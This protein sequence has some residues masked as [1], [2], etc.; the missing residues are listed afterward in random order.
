MP[1]LTIRDD[2]GDRHVAFVPGLS[3]LQLLDAAQV[4]IRGGCNGRGG[5]GLCLVRISAGDAGELAPIECLHLD[6][7]QLAQG[8][9][10]ACQALPQTDLT[11]QVLAPPP[12]AAWRYLD[13]R[14]QPPLRRTPAVP[15][16]LGTELGQAPYG[17][18]VD[19]GTTHLCLSLYDR[20][21]GQ[22][23][24]GCHGFNPQAAYGT[25]IMTRLAAAVASPAQAQ[26][27]SQLVVEG[28]GA[29]LWGLAIRAGIPLQHIGAVTL[30]GNTAMLALLSGRQCDRLLVP[31]QWALPIDCRPEA[32]DEWVQTW[33]IHPGARI[34][35]IAP[36]AGLI[37][38]DL[39]AGVLATD[40][41]AAEGGQ[42][43][44]DFGTNSE[45]AFWDG[46]VLWCTSAAGGPAFEGS[47]MRCGFPAEPGAIE[48]VEFADDGLHV[49]VIGGAQPQGLCGSG[50]VDLM[51]GLV[52]SGQL[53]SRGRFTSGVPEEGFHLGVGGRDLV[54][55]GADVD[56][57]QRAKAAIGVGI[58]VLL[59]RAGWRNKDLRQVCVGGAFGR[60][61]AIGNAQALG[62]LP[63]IAPERIALCGNTALAGCTAALLSPA[64]RER[65][66]RLVG[67]SRV[68]NLSACP[69]FDERFLDHLYLR[70]MVV[71]GP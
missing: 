69:D 36:V 34:D 3:L 2:T 49:Q 42:L 15:P 33:D 41:T 50:V 13:P 22:W 6:E 10:L 68:I 27:M 64:A 12:Q 5:C 55:T 37:G 30:V 44:I 59:D 58:S 66:Q 71:P 21:T 67:Q 52:R 46:E 4:R 19:L 8:I 54:F 25:D 62:L 23:Q 17:A 18:A 57:F 31:S 43:L 7:G 47:G 9:R 51:A 32:T 20:R 60:A 24:A 35:A 53:S 70:P 29:A 63:A 1:T 16:E 48:R 65:C 39:L 14:D 11:L 26:R 38:S 56:L 28:L 61:L 45:L 40:L